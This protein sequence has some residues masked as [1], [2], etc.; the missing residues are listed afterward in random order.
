MNTLDKKIVLLLVEDEKILAN[1]LEEKLVSEGFTVLKAY[2]GEEGLKMA[3]ENHPNLILLDL[4]MPK[5]DGITMLKGL[6]KDSW[7]ARAA[8]IILTNLESSDKIS[9]TLDVSFGNVFE[10]M[11][12][13]NWSLEDIVARIK[14]RLQIKDSK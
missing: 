9:E 4:L 7:G 8:V 10:Y 2:D 11:L 3:L 12:K 5:V 6:R 1:T 13:T 14:E